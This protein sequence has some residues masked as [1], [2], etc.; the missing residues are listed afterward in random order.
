VNCHML[1]EEA[2]AAHLATCLDCQAV[3]QGVVMQGNNLD[4]LKSAALKELR[5]K[6]KAASWHWWLVAIL[7]VQTFAAVAAFF[8]LSHHTSQFASERLGWASSVAWTALAVFSSWAAM[9][10][11]PRIFR[12][13]SPVA[14]V[15]CACLGLFAASGFDA[16]A[17]GPGCALTDGL[18]SAIPMAFVLF[19]LSDMT[20]DLSRSLSA[21]IAVG[22][23]GLLASHL[24]CPD[25]RLS[26]L[27]AFHLL[28]VAVFAPAVVFARA[29]L[30]TLAHA[31]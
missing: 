3:H 19:L 24:H 23:T 9:A 2:D 12:F 14:F 25:G 16:G 5:A 27:L 13:V 26:H 1:F 28:P 15:A 10:P 30:P 29:R 8:L 18:V 21:G 7:G 6:P 31:P 22:A 17:R 20:P 11:A 4:A